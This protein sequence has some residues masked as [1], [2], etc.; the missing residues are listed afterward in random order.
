[1]TAQ[2]GGLKGRTVIKIHLAE[3]GAQTFDLYNLQVFAKH[4]K[5]IIK[6]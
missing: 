5:K 6:Q 4:K 3:Q 1:M 2:P